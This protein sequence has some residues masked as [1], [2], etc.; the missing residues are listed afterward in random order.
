M[1]RLIIPGLFVLS[2]AAGLIFE[3]VWSRQL[4]LVFGNTTQAVS[5]IL[6]GFFGGMA[7]GSSI[8]GKVADRIRRPLRL[9]GFLELGLVIVVLFTPLSFRLIDNVYG[10][11]FGAF[12]TSPTVVSLLRFSLALVALA[13][14]TI[15]MGATLPALTRYLAREASNLSGAFSRLYAANTIGAVFG[16]ACAGLILI[17]LFGLS[18]TLLIGAAC[19]AIAGLFALLLDTRVSRD[20]IDTRSPP[21]VRLQKLDTSTQPEQSFFGLSLVI[22]FVSG[23]TSLG[24]Q[25]LWTRLIASGTGSSTYVFTIILTLFLAGLGLGAVEY[26]RIHMRVRNVLPVLAMAQIALGVLGVLGMYAING[27]DDFSAALQWKAL[28]VVLPA[29]FVM[30]FCFPAAS[31]LVGGTDSEVGGRT[32]FLLAA[33]TTGAIIGAFVVPFLLIPAI[34]SPASLAV[35][36]GTNT[37]FGLFLALHGRT[38]RK[39]RLSLVAASGVGAAALALSVAVGVFV[40]PGVARMARAGATLYRSDED[41]IASVQAGMVEGVK[42]LWVTGFS[43]TA[44]TVD[45]KL[46]AILPLTLRPASTSL[47]AIAFGMGS[48]YRSSLIAGLRTDVVEL[49]PSVPKVFDTFYPDAPA[50]LANRNGRV[51]VADGR[52]HVERADRR[53]DIV[54][55]DPPPP[56][57]SAGVSVISSREFYLA[58]KRRLMPGGVMMQWVPWSQALDDFKNHVRTFRDVFP[59]VIVAAGPGGNGFF[60]LGSELPLGFE[61]GAMSQVLGRPGVLDDISS[62]S[63]SP[64]KTLEGWMDLLPQLVRLSGD[65]V[66][67]FAGPGELITDDRPLPE[68]FLLKRRFGSWI[69]YLNPDEIGR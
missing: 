27:L 19:S 10:L 15:L 8:G 16:A 69:G 24:Y 39:M 13:P 25:V 31:A 9:Y 63:D 52:S 54:V 11:A 62:A 58:S 6:T 61:A 43:M 60:L 34:G 40:D 17:E 36:A 5:A 41:E 23:L 47:L 33:N 29:T 1:Q 55:V 4:V 35:V 67:R 21:P 18:G 56:L 65:K 14:A 48:T 57:E 37:I 20:S 53:Y 66:A 59:H 7:I 26:K 49:V 45:A 44:L 2:G 30:G 38:P 12:E 51:I 50:I 22:A 3:V 68:Y 64:E 46:M 42:H 32:G 28:V